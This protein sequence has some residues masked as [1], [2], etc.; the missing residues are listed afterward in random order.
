MFHATG[1]HFSSDRSGRLRRLT[2]RDH[3]LLSWLADRY[4][5]S[6]QQIATALFPLSLGRT[7]GQPAWCGL[8]DTWTAARCCTPPARWV[9]PATSNRATTERTPKCSAADPTGRERCTPARATPPPL[10]AFPENLPCGGAEC[11]RR[12]LLHRRKLRR[13]DRRD[14]LVSQPQRQRHDREGLRPSL[15]RRHRAQLSDRPA[16]R[17]RRP[18]LQ[19]G[20]QRELHAR[21]GHHQRRQRCRHPHQLSASASSSAPRLAP[22]TAGRPG[23]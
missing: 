19:P 9:P 23:T 14:Q 2:V 3:P 21:R 6:T 22:P 8:R 10:T 5:A 18:R 12:R 7:A 1:S 11:L 15:G 16:R 20:F 4:V 13:P 17:Q